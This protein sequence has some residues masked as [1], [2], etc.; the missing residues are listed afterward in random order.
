VLIA[1]VERGLPNTAMRAFGPEL[2]QDDI[3]NVVGYMQ[4]HFGKA[5]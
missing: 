5:K 1:S 3:R 4:Q 2:G